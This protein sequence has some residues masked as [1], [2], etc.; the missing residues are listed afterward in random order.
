MKNIL[1]SQDKWNEFYK[2]YVKDLEFEVNSAFHYILNYYN[3]YYQLDESDNWKDYIDTLNLKND[4]INN[5]KVTNINITIDEEKNIKDINNKEDRIIYC[6][7]SNNF[8]SGALISPQ[9]SY[10]HIVNKNLEIKP[11]QHCWTLF[12]REKI[13]YFP[14]PFYSTGNLPVLTWNKTGNEFLLN[15]KYYSNTGA[16]WGNY[17]TFSINPQPVRYSLELSDGE[18]LIF[19]KKT[20]G[21]FETNLF[22]YSTGSTGSTGST[23]SGKEAWDGFKQIMYEFYYGDEEIID[24]NNYLEDTVWNQTTNTYT[25]KVNRNETPIKNN[26]K[27][28]IW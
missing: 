27:V 28:R 21:T 19:L 23:S 6:M 1:G 15:S 26:I 25:I 10:L 14:T 22:A 7:N 12:K 16:T 11:E 13:L 17:T 3:L 24:D 18:S 8:F 4:D 5:N 9:N 20:N 2:L